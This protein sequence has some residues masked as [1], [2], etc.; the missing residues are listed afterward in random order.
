MCFQYKSPFDLLFDHYRVAV[1]ERTF[2]KLEKN[3]LTESTIEGRLNMLLV[4]VSKTGGVVSH[5]TKLLKWLVEKHINELTNI[6]AAVIRSLMKRGHA[7]R[8]PQDAW[9]LLL[10][11]GRDLGL[12]GEPSELLL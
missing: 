4:L 2:R 5:V 10:T 6:R 3:I 1:F 12:D 8:L 9:N 7:W 11:F